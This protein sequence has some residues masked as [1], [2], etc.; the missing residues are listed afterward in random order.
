MTAG[1]GHGAPLGP[2]AALALPSGARRAHQK[3][4]SWFVRALHAFALPERQALLVRFGRDTHAAVRKTFNGLRDQAV[5]AVGAADR[6]RTASVAAWLAQQNPLLPPPAEVSAFRGVL[7][8][9]GPVV[10]PVV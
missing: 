6:E 9:V 10:N 8:L 5:T 4:E 7:G 3:W 2:K 1:F